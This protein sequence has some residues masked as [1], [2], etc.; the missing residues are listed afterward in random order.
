LLPCDAVA[1]DTMC[2]TCDRVIR[3]GEGR[4]RTPY[5]DHHAECFE[6]NPANV[7]L[8]AFARALT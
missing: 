8:K 7:W 6:E 2:S 1:A 4:Y 3:D 5:G